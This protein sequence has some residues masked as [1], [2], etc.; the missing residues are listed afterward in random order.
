MAYLVRKGCRSAQV[1]VARFVVAG[2]WN[3]GLVL[4]RLRDEA[5]AL[6]CPFRRACDHPFGLLDCFN[7][8]VFTGSR[9]RLTNVLLGDLPRLGLRIRLLSHVSGSVCR[10]GETVAAL[11]VL[12][13]THGWDCLGQLF[14]VVS[15]RRIFVLLS[16]IPKSFVI[17]DVTVVVWDVLVRCWQLL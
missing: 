14:S 5:D 11:G 16:I 4:V 6:F 1:R 3:P 15:E 7:G 12:V 9:A 8:V 2:S 17:F 10:F 13:V